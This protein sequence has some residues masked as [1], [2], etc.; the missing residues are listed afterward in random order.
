MSL[1]QNTSR[2][3]PE[4]EICESSINYLDSQFPCPS[5][6]CTG[7]PKIRVRVRVSNK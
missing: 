5:N 7:E 1:N 2:L 4:D 3:I 6:V